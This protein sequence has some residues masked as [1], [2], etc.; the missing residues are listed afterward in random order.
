[1]PSSGP[2]T[3]FPELVKCINF[4][5]F[6][7]NYNL[8][9]IWYNI[10]VNA[11]MLAVFI[12]TFFACMLAIIYIKE[13]KIMAMGKILYV[14]GF[15]D[16]LH[17]DL[18][19]FSKKEGVSPGAIIEEAFE[20]WKQNKKKIPMKHH[21]VLWS[22]EK[23]LTNFLKKM[24]EVTKDDWFQLYTASQT[25]KSEKFFKSHGWSLATNSKNSYEK[26]PKKYYED[27]SKNLKGDLKHKQAC[28]IGVQNSESI[29]HSLQLE[30][31]YNKKR[32]EGVALCCYDTIVFEKINFSEIYDLFEDHDRIF[33]LRDG[34]TLELSLSKQNP[35]KMLL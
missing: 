20:Q 34:E 33:I 28:I 16:D 30:K 29:K 6:G 13:P 5:R 15:N 17:D 11:C 18:N 2:S 21:L 19:Q 31:I 25:K 27:V 4:H 10:H 1:M 24:D 3:T 9:V 14:R 26:N 35:L 7:A 8:F 22:N 32:V 12:F 23:D